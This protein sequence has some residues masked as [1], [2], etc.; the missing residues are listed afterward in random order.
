MDYSYHNETQMQ[1]LSVD[2]TF[3]YIDTSYNMFIGPPN[4]NVKITSLIFIKKY[5]NVDI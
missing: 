2:D 4:I 3:N 1:S 5:S